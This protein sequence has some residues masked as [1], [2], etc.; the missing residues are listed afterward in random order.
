MDYAEFKEKYALRL[1]AQQEHAVQAIDGYNLLLAVPGSGKTTVLVTR[2]GN[3]VYCRGIEP[4]SIL[5]MTYTV[6]ATRDMRDRF[7]SFF[8]PE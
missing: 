7:E 4:K 8:G 5:T 6:A 1:S 3:M 2:L